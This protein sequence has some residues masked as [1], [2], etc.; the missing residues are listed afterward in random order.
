MKGNMNNKQ[1]IKYGIEIL[2]IGATVILML[3][4]VNEMTK[5]PEPVR[6][7]KEFNLNP[8]RARPM[9]RLVPKIKPE[10]PAPKVLPDTL[11]FPLPELWKHFFGPKGP[12]LKIPKKPYD[13]YN[14]DV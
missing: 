14:H 10:I 8:N 13:R 6:T 4:F 9:P 11:K 2:L 1:A 12:R 3:L 7:Q 5:D